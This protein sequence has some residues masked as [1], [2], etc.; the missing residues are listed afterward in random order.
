VPHSPSATPADAPSDDPSRGRPAVADAALALRRD[1][2]GLH[3][4]AHGDW[5]LRTAA[6][7]RA[8]LDE[9]PRAA[10]GE[11]VALDLDTLGELDTSGALLLCQLIERQREAGAAVELRGGDPGQRR[12]LQRVRDAGSAPCPPQPA[13]R[14]AFAAAVERLGAGCCANVALMLDF[15]AF[16]GRATRVFASGLLRPRQWRITSLV[17]HMEQVGLNALPIIALIAFLIGVVV[18]YQGSV[19][20]ARFGA[21]I[22]VVDGMALSILRE[23][24]ILLTAVVVAGRSGSAFTAQLGSMVVNEEVD[25]LRALGL[26]PM[27]V[28]VLPRVWA[29]TLSL[30]LL[31]FIADLAGLL[32]GALVCWLALDIGPALF[33]ERLSGAVDAWDLFVGLVKAP[34]FAVLIGLIGCHNG[35]AVERSAESVGRLTTRAVVQAIFLVIVADALFSV[36]FGYIG[37]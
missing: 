9:L 36:F 12:L 18:A 34:V 30:P 11:A 23:L 15:V 29:L 7:L 19:Q 2:D 28:L 13:P 37:L 10:G 8:R 33:I 17:H 5:Q 3:F 6:A 21:Q 22:F 25:A 24:A 16:L 4:S 32:G 20:L 1:A 27:H 14:N 26:D 35:L 31:A